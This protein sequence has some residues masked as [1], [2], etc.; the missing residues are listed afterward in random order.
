MSSTLLQLSM[1]IK[2]KNTIE[3][4][5]Q[6]QAKPPIICAPRNEPRPIPS[7]KEIMSK[8]Y[9][10]QRHKVSKIFKDAVKGGL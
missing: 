10:F 5:K 3:S 6:K 9:Y 8:K 2:E 7:L 4:H 1:L